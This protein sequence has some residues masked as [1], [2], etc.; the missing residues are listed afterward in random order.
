MSQFRDQ[1]WNDTVTVYHRVKTTGANGKTVTNWTTQTVE[2]V[3]YG[4]SKRQVV[5][6]TVLVEQDR[7]ICRIPGDKL[8]ILE[9]GDVICR[10]TV[11]IEIP[12]NSSPEKYLTEVEHFTASIVSDDRPLRKT[13]HWYAAEA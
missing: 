6:N 10:G 7:H 5:N 3:F 12:E 9:R 1:R 13:S 4:H 2:G 8:S 11:S